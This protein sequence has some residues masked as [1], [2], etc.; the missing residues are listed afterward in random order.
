MGRRLFG[1]LCLAL[2]AA[3][4][5]WLWV[6]TQD[7]RDTVPSS[8]TPVS[9]VS[10]RSPRPPSS[11][12][13]RGEPQWLSISGLLSKTV[14]HPGGIT[15]SGGRVT[16][17]DDRPVFWR[18]SNLP[19]TDSVGTA[20]ILGHNY[21][22]AGVPPPFSVLKSVQIGAT[23]Q[24]GVPAG[25]LTY[26]VQQVLTPPKSAMADP[27]ALTGLKQPVPGRLVLMTC[28]TENGHDTFYQFIVI[29]QLE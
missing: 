21:A 11:A 1:A 29:A 2:A 13:P 12:V 19:G 6:H 24:V 28:D 22:S 16:P 20:V 4:I 5:A 9:I 26:R 17:V 14:L 3:L 7:R 18:E 23:V 8:E 25:T 10:P 15:G 27:T